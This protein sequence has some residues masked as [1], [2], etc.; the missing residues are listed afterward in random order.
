MAKHKIFATAI[1]GP[2]DG[3]PIE[4]HGDIHQVLRETEGGY[5]RGH[6]EWGHDTEGKY[7]TAIWKGWDSDQP[8][9]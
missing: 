2:K 7:W 3:E 1:G 9:P 8:Q 6:Y 5:Q 4:V